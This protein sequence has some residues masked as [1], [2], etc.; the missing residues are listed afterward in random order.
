[1]PPSA[2]PTPHKHTAHPAPRAPPPPHPPPPPP[3]PPGGGGG[4]GG[5]GAR[6][7][8]RQGVL[9]CYTAT[10]VFAPTSVGNDLLWPRAWGHNTPRCEGAVTG[11][12]PTLPHAAF[13]TQGESADDW[14]TNESPPVP[15]RP[16]G[17]YRPCRPGQGVL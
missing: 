13:N 17:L 14:P 8:R 1:A 4:G 9:L 5:G 2:A 12:S 3:P 7:R 10:P 11:R 15:V 16:G 6:K